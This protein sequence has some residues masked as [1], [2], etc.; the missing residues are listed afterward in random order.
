[1]SLEI[2]LIMQAHHSDHCC[3]LPLFQAVLLIRIWHSTDERMQPGQIDIVEILLGVKNAMLSLQPV[4]VVVIR[5]VS[6]EL[7]LLS[8]RL[9]SLPNL[10]DINVS[11]PRVQ[12][13]S[14]RLRTRQSR[15]SQ[16]SRQKVSRHRLRAR[17]ARH[18]TFA[19]VSGD[20]SGDTTPGSR[21]CVVDGSRPRQPYSPGVSGIGHSCRHKKGRPFCN[22]TIC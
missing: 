15:V 14:Q 1:M 9:P 13:G 17:F 8:S 7:H 21:R 6:T 2:D 3:G 11:V 22:P 10:I 4:A 18:V 16:R 20:R 12:V 19:T 5:S